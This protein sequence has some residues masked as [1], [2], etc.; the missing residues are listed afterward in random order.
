MAIRGVLLDLD[1]TV[2]L[3]RNQVPGA[4][5]FVA[6][7]RERGLRC[8]FVTNRANRTP[9]E[10]CE[11]LQGYGIPCGAEDILTSAQ[12][13]AQYLRQGSAFCIGEHGLR[14][15]M[16]EA[17]LRLTAERPDYVV[18]SYDREFNYAKLTQACRLIAAGATY[19]ATNPDRALK[20]DQGIV[21]G[22]GA[23]IAAVTAGCGQMPVIIGKPERRII[24][25][26]LA[27]LGMPAAEVMN[28]GD[29]LETD[30]L[31]GQ[32]AGVRTALLL[33]GVSTRADADRFPTA[34]TWIAE[35]YAALT[36]IVAAENGW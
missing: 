5:D 16:E 17:G 3:G 2:Y 24:D 12:A 26:A 20:T 7:L 29:N 19:I 18:V 6:R 31:A 25:M 34:P 35:D 10:V 33:T 36:R 30:V 32:R 27:R 14:V 21:P 9:Q 13:T 15:A 23:I 4:A 1:G 22:T 8:L 28:V 11:H